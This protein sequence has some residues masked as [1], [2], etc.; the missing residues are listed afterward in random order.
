MTREEGLIIG[1]YTGVLMSPSFSDL[2]TFIEE[3]ME[4][5]VLT[6]E[7]GDKD[8]MN[9]LKEKVKPQFIQVV[10]SQLKEI[11]DG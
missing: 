5:P 3:I 11:D 1:A 8:F 2:H 4:R 7:M 6:H 10:E 9:E